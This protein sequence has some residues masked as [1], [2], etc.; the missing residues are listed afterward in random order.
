MIL[1]FLTS[2]P[3]FAS[4]FRLLPLFTGESSLFF[5][6]LLTSL[7]IFEDDYNRYRVCAAYSPVGGAYIIE[8][9]RFPTN[10]VGCYYC[11]KVFF[12][13]F[14]CGSDCIANFCTVDIFIAGLEGGYYLYASA[15]GY[16][17]GYDWVLCASFFK[18][19]SFCSSCSSDI[20]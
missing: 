6:S 18:L 11:A 5:V 20:F 12:S 16:T 7:I 4:I 14:F 13:S 17:R 2:S 19:S 8:E 15:F 1:S 10:E 9:G 3:L